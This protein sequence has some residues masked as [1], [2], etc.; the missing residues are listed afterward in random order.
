MKVENGNHLIAKD[1]KLL[2]NKKTGEVYGNELWLGNIDSV[3]NY[4]EVDDEE[5]KLIKIK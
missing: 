2:K 4:E 1:G 5:N 3:D